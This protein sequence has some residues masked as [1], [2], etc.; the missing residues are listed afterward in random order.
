MEVGY[1]KAYRHVIN[2]LLRIPYTHWKLT[3]AALAN[4]TKEAFLIEL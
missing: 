2:V 3:C 4:P 1:V